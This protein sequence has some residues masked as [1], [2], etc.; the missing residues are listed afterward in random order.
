MRGIVTAGS[1]PSRN[2]LAYRKV[3]ASSL[4]EKWRSW[5]YVC[6]SAPEFPGENSW[7]IAEDPHAKHDYNFL[8]CRGTGLTNL[9][10][11][12][13][14]AKEPVELESTNSPNEEY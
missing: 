11:P 7:C 1:L 6:G 10:V 4:H 5:I 14:S 12:Q 2:L 9:K 8:F 13:E 3:P